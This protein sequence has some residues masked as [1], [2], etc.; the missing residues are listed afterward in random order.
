MRKIKEIICNV[1]FIVGTFII[2]LM[3]GGLHIVDSPFHIYV[4]NYKNVVGF[5]LNMIVFIFL[6]NIY[7]NYKK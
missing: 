7:K 3:V 6:L 4:D 1:F 5:W 2:S